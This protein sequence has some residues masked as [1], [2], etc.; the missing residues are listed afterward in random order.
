MIDSKLVERFAALYQGYE[1]AY[2]QFKSKNKRDERGKLIGRSWT[3]HKV[4][5]LGLYRAHL[6]GVEPSLGIALLNEAEEC[7]FGVIDVDIY[8]LPDLVE[9]EKKVSKLGLPITIVRSKSL[10]GHLTIFCDVGVPPAILQKKL[11]EWTAMMGYSDKTEKFP[12][13][14]GRASTTDIGNWINLPY[15]NAENTERYAV[16]NGEKLSLEE[17]LDLAESRRVTREDLEDLKY[18][19]GKESDL[20]FEGPPCLQ[21]LQ[22]K[23]GFVDGTKRQGMFDV[24]VYLRKRYPEGW[25]DKLIEY[26]KEM[27]DPALRNDEIQSIIKSLGKKDYGYQCKQPPINEYCQRKVCLT[28]KFGIVTD[29]SRNSPGLEISGI[30]AYKVEG[31][32]EMPM[33]AMDIDG[34]RIIMDNTTF[35]RKSLFN[36]M[37]L[38]M[39]Q[40]VPIHVSEAKWT[41]VVHEL[42]ETA[43]IIYTPKEIS[44]TGHLE[45]W[46][47]AYLHGAKC[48]SMAQIMVQ[49]AYIEDGFVYCRAK[50]LISFLDSHHVKYR[51]HYDV[52]AILNKAGGTSKYTYIP[53]HGRANIWKIPLADREKEPDLQPDFD[54]VTPF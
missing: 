47:E 17:F 5:T 29:G 51:N 3:E 39:I 36:Q 11:E 49:G 15:F 48:T 40:K 23:G 18:G 26:N 45:E 34:R 31:T 12:K 13:Q 32:N 30:T 44:V 22:S 28:R 50:D 14:T 52:W 41:Q 8:P 16:F 46:V 38:G 24:G 54:Q 43:D 1:L 4:V 21:L 19:V 7:H 37:C 27:C 42:A 25:E 2:G 35:Y 53:K 6:E 10:G 33:W 20:F 9:L